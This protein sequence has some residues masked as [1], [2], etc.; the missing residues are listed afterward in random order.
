MADEA[1]GDAREGRG[2][3]DTVGDDSD[4]DSAAWGQLSE[5]DV[6]APVGSWANLEADCVSS[7][8][9]SSELEAPPLSRKRT[10][11]LSSLPTQWTTTGMV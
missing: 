10:M 8:E 6:D 3:W 4:L 5:D 7:G 2:A 9:A 1:G 11:R